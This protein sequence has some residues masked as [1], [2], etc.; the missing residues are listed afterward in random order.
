MYIRIMTIKIIISIINTHLLKYLSVNIS[1]FTSSSTMKTIS[2]RTNSHKI[3][4]S[5]RVRGGRSRA[6]R[7]IVPSS[8]AAEKHISIGRIMN[9]NCNE[10]L[11]LIMR[12]HQ[13]ALLC[14]LSAVAAT[15]RILHNLV[16]FVVPLKSN[17][18]NRDY[19]V[20]V[21]I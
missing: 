7:Y 20:Y 5:S 2:M 17:Q 19:N 21:M 14:F 12:G 11:I 15:V 4:G 6:H 18:I 13:L 1:H 3:R 9:N 8:T 10:H 16:V